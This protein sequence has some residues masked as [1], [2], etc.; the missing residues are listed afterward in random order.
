MTWLLSGLSRIL[1]KLVSQ[2]KAKDEEQ[3][4]EPNPPSLAMLEG[5]EVFRREW[6]PGTVNSTVLRALEKIVHLVG[7]ERFRG[8]YSPETEKERQRVF[9]DTSGPL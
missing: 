6:N 7:L 2:T 3:V 4:G 5:F 8:I 9:P 1:E